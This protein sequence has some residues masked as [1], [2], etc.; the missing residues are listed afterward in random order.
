MILEAKHNIKNTTSFDTF[1]VQLRGSITIGIYVMATFV[2]SKSK[3][4]IVEDFCLDEVTYLKIGSTV[5]EYLKM[6]SVLKFYKNELGNDIVGK[7]MNQIKRHI[8]KNK[9]FFI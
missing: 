8:N 5:I 6:E 2:K 4:D 3:K 1:T 9:Q 7:A